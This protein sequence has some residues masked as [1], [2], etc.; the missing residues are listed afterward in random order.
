MLSSRSPRADES[1]VIRLQTARVLIHK[2]GGAA[3]ALGS[4][5]DDILSH[6]IDEEG[7]AR[8]VVA[9]LDGTRLREGDAIPVH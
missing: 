6:V 8:A 2:Q 4:D 5:L 7:D 1:K 3:R 9:V